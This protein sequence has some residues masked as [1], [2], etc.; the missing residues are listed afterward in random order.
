MKTGGGSK[1]RKLNLENFDPSGPRN[2]VISSP[3]SLAACEVLGIQPEELFL[4]TKDEFA[5]RIELEGIEAGNTDEAYPQYIDGMKTIVEQLCD[6][7]NQLIQQEEEGEEEGEE[8]EDQEPVAYP[9]KP[10]RPASANRAKA[11]QPQRS[12]IPKTDK[13]NRKDGGLQDEDREKPKKSKQRAVSVP[14]DQEEE[15]ELIKSKPIGRKKQ[16]RKGPG[17]KNRPKTADPSEAMMDQFKRTQYLK[18]ISDEEDGEAEEY[19]P[20]KPHRREA[21]GSRTSK[22]STSISK[23]QEIELREQ[24]H[25]SNMIKS[26]QRLDQKRQL[27]MQKILRDNVNAKKIKLLKEGKAV[28]HAEDRKHRVAYLSYKDSDRE[29]ALNKQKISEMYRQ[30]DVES[31]RLER[32]QWASVKLQ[33]LQQDRQKRTLEKQIEWDEKMNR[34]HNIKD[35]EEFKRGLIMADICLEN[36]RFNLWKYGS[37]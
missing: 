12:D 26:N 2:K 31:K 15:P 10:K 35:V 33:R 37:Y 22:P 27:L 14:E 32:S 17:S 4:W 6:L 19:E 36:E 23:V 5:K 24:R 28:P 1:G 11:S 9:N 21:L 34:V 3:R 25:Q 13:M 8:Y 16:T 18:P 20:E 30:Q 29:R 7:R